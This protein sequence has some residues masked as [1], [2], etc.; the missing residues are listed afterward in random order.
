MSWVWLGPKERF[1]RGQHCVSAVDIYVKKPT[2]IRPRHLHCDF[3]FKPYQLQQDPKQKTPAVL[4]G[5]PQHSPVSSCDSSSAEGSGSKTEFPS[6]QIQMDCPH[7]DHRYP[8]I[9]SPPPALRF[10]NIYQFKGQQCNAL[11]LEQR[12]K[13]TSSNMYIQS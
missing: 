6:E 2:L 11:C 4:T 12:K 1:E 8:D 5:A 9:C 3:L 13:S 7:H 10:S